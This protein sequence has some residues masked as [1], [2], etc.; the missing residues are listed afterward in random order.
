MSKSKFKAWPNFAK[1]AKGH[2]DLQ[3]HGGKVEFKNIK[4]RVLD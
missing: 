3:D 2:I 1:A 4:I